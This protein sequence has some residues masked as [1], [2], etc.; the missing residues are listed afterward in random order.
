MEDEIIVGREV[1]TNIE[2]SKIIQKLLELQVD[3][4]YVTSIFPQSGLE[5]RTKVTIAEVLQDGLVIY[6]GEADDI[7]RTATVELDSETYS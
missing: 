5:V 3:S 4:C 7:D 1:E 2:L 6:S